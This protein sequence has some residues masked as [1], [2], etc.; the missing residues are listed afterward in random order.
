MAEKNWAAIL[1][2]EDRIIANSDR[3]FRDHCYSLESMSEELTYKERSIYIQDDFTE[4]LMAEDFVDTVQSEKLAH[5][6]RQLTDRQRYAIELAF[7][8]GYQYKEIAGILDCSP[9]AVTLLLQRAFYR[10]RIFLA[11]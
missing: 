3:R 8:E 2:D 11:E 10:L 7:W 9:A 4:E 6:L 1:K 5:G